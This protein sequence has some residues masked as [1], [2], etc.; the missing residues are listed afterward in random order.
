M[1]TRARFVAVV[2]ERPDAFEQIA[3]YEH[4]RYLERVAEAVQLSADLGPA[5][6]CE[7]HTELIGGT[8]S[9]SE[10]PRAQ[11]YERRLSATERAR[12]G[13]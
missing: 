12:L 7:K 3:A 5:C 11:D 2:S 4:E 8:D 9:E 6:D 10:T 13:L 1:S